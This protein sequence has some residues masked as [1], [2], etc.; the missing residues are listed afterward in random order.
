MD[1]LEIVEKP[2]SFLTDENGN[3]LTDENTNRLFIISL[4]P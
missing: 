3:Y 1:L 4:N 2:L